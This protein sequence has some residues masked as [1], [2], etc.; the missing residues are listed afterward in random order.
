MR[1]SS[2]GY[3]LTEIMISM[4]IQA[5]FIVVLAS[6]F[7][8]M[9]SFYTKSQQFLTARSRGQRVIMYIDTR[10][11]HAGLGVWRCEDSKEIAALLGSIKFL[12]DSQKIN[13]PVSVTSSSQIGSSY[14]ISPSGVCRGD[15]LTVL[16]AYQEFTTGSMPIINE[17]KKKEIPAS[18]T[19]QPQFSFMY[20]KW[21]NSVTGN[22]SDIHTYAV[23]EATGLPLYSKYDTKLQLRLYHASPTSY[24]KKAEVF[25]G[26]ELLHIDCQRMFAEDNSFYFSYPKDEWKKYPHEAGILELYMELHAPD[27][28]PKILDLWVLSTGGTDTKRNIDKPATWPGRWKPEY[29]HEVVYVSRASWTLHNIPNSFKFS[30]E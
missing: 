15:V 18:D 9:L 28:A 26:S 29:N 6:A 4:L 13:L 19:S 3:I 22:Q 25:P 21:N 23:M 5:M 17:S 7:Y 24:N 1:Q 30:Y 20:D 8:M 2:K 14:D 12:K 27:N 16:Y 11:R 10:I